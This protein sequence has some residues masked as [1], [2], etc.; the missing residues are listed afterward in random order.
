MKNKFLPGAV[1]RGWDRVMACTS[2][3]DVETLVSVK[4]T[5]AEV[6]ARI[7]VVVGTYNF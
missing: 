4:T 7:R 3:Q 1:V 6:P 5:S 2:L